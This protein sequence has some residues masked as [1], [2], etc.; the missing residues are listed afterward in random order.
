MSQQSGFAKSG[1]ADIYYE[2]TGSGLPVVFCHAGV[3][4]RRLWDPQFANPVPGFRY[5]RSDMRGFGN[6][7]WVAEPYKPHRDIRA[8]ID[9]LDLESLLL[10]G[11]S[12]GGKATLELSAELGS[13]VPGIMVV[14]AGLPGWSPDDGGYT[15][16]Q[17]ENLDPLWEAKDWDAIVGIDAEVWAVGMG[18]EVSDVDPAFLALMME[19][20]LKAVT[21]ELER[22][23]YMTWMEP[24]IS[25]RMDEIEARATV[26]VGEH[27]L[28]DVVTSTG[29]LAERL[30]GERI[31]IPGTA[32]LP[33]L[34]RPVE[35]NAILERFLGSFS[36][37]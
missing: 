29:H 1:R 20:D 28:P 32:H 6:S 26:V 11:C 23:E 5:I 4:D 13:R 3:S 31:V 33:S 17:W 12:M 22:D 9:H 8:V 18:R 2:E 36:T 21:T 19:M 37:S 30:G 24:P 27:D 25:E 7:E 16:P 10:V 14:G 34:E 35:F 15:P